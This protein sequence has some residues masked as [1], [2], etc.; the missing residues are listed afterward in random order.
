M[1]KITINKKNYDKDK[2]KLF[3]REIE[4]LK[5]INHP[6]IIK[7]YDYNELNEDVFWSLNDYCNLGSLDNLIKDLNYTTISTRHRFIEH[8]I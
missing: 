6:Y 8:I 3:K 2:L 7:L 1:I 5:S 4:I